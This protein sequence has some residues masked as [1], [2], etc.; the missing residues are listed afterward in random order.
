MLHRL[1]EISD[2]AKWTKSMQILKGT[3]IIWHKRRLVS[4]LYMDQSVKLQ[5]DQ[6][7]TKV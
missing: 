1:A 4:K 2:H 3:G 5:L 7:E 6:G